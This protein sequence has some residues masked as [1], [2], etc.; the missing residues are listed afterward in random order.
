[1]ESRKLATAAWRAIAAAALML[2]AWGMAATVDKA[3]PVTVS[4][5]LFCLGIGGR[6]QGRRA[7]R[8]LEGDEPA[9]SWRLYWHSAGLGACGGL[10]L[11]VGLFVF[12]P[13]L[14][15]SPAFD[16]IPRGIAVLIAGTW[17]AA[18]FG[19]AAFSDV[20]AGEET[21]PFSTSSTTS[22]AEQSAEPSLH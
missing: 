2:G 22:T 9:G 6:V 14:V 17:F 10:L 18:L 11:A 7:S 12:L 4:E 3:P 8:S 15:H 21:A 20:P 16:K 13:K 1:M 5:V 19:L